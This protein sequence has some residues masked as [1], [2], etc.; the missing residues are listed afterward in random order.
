MLQ[1]DVLVAAELDG[2]GVSQYLPAQLG[3]VLS[4]DLLEYH[5]VVEEP[6]IPVAF[7]GYSAIARDRMPPLEFK[8]GSWFPIWVGGLAVIS[9][10]GDV[11]P[12]TPADPGLILD[13]GDGPLNLVWS[14]LVLVVFSAAVYA[15]AIA[16]RPPPERVAANISQLPTDEP[17]KL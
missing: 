11:D 15:Y 6:V 7:A 5:L 10:L 16:V 2:I 14:A 12:G 3:A 13:G 8:A 17:A 4:I 9:Y 1:S